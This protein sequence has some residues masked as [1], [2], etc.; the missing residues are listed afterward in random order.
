M[1]VYGKDLSYRKTFGYWLLG[2]GSG[3]S[4]GPY[5]MWNPDAFS[6]SVGY[7]IQLGNFSYSGSFGWITNGS[8]GSFFFTGISGGT[9]QVGI[10]G[11]LQLSANFYNNNTMRQLSIVDYAG[12]GYSYGANLYGLSVD[13]G[14]GV[15]AKGMLDTSVFSSLGI[16]VGAGFGMHGG[17]TETTFLWGY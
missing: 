1:Y 17:V 9:T 5:K 4:S 10:G 11:S 2:I 7:G 16:G 13:Y 14:G 6:I 8:E 15:T 3:A 12:K